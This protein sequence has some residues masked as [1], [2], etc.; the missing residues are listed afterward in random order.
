M[1]EKHEAL[2]RE[3]VETY[4]Q[5]A[6][7]LSEYFRGI[8]PRTEHIN[9][10]FELAGNPDNAKVLEIGCGDGRDAAE[11][12]KRANWYIGFDISKSMIELAEQHVP[13]AD[14]E[15][16]DAVHYNYPPDMDIVFAFASLLH[17]KNDDM[18]RVMN[19]VADSLRVGGIFYLS[20]KHAPQ[21]TPT[22]KEDQHG[23]RLFYLY[24]EDEIQSIA[25]VSGYFE[26]V[27]LEKEVIGSTTW[28]EMALMRIEKPAMG[29]VYARNFGSR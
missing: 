5:S 16:A 7:A 17:I 14:F 28:L 12:V 21:Y 18:G 29:H 3:T 8:G 9:K 26:T 1:I 10:A 24:S 11:I 25:D 15:V 2:M 22:I 20:L 23:R 4:N 27:S 6:E 13:D 19:K